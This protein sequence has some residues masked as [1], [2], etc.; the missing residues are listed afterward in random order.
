ML[1][2][3]LASLGLGQRAPAPDGLSDGD[4]KAL[5]TLLRECDDLEPGLGEAVSAY[6]LSGEGESL[7]LRLRVLPGRQY[8]LTGMLAVPVRTFQPPST[9][10]EDKAATARNVQRIQARR[11]AL[12]GCEGWNPALFRR[13][14]QVAAE[15]NTRGGLNQH[16][17]PGSAASPGWF[18]GV[19]DVVEWSW[20][21]N[22]RDNG[23]GTDTGRIGVL[24]AARCLEMLA[25][26]GLGT[27][28]L[29]DVCFGSTDYRSSILSP[30]LLQ[31]ADL[32]AVLAAGVGGVVTGL[33]RL[34]AA[35][36]AEAL[37]WLGQAVGLG[38]P[39]LYDAVAA[40][41]VGGG[42]QVSLAA[43]T[44]LRRCDRARVRD[45]G[46]MLLTRRS[47]REG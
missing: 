33:R 3:V 40:L 29:I 1:K 41:L 28:S 24:S 8:C 13:L 34:G 27:E 6:V 5:A 11:R 44:A 12:L 19:L 38:D 23:D 31:L 9:W 17:G 39:A 26:D 2:N 25:I 4:R 45:T 14:G 20:L 42:K 47:T 16:G 43:L 7:L 21:Q 46:A 36:Q 30:H 15:I 10:E 22:K 35:G 37:D 18:R 32:P